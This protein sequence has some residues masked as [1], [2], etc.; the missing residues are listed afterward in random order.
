[1]NIQKIKIPIKQGLILISE[2]I[3]LSY[4]CNYMNKSSG[5]I[6]NKMNHAETSTTSIGFN[7]KDISD[8]NSAIYNIGK[9]L[10][11]KRIIPIVNEEIDIKTRKEDTVR[12]LKEIS[13][14]ISMPYIYVNKLG[15]NNVWYA[16]RTAKA[17]RYK[18]SSEDILAI[19]MAIV[20]IGSKL[21]S[22]ELTL[23]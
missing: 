20:E 15:K 16:K 2:M 9:D 6:Y 23:A 7:E 4:L 22:I 10:L 1:M 13:L 3:K 21:T 11:D 12:Q 14:I 5:W 18:F 17:S 8:I 19:N